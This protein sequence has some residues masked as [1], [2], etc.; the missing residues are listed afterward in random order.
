MSDS[1][2]Q[3]ER[4][5]KL[6]TPLGEEK[7]A[8]V[9]FECSEAVSE[10]FV[11]RIDA[12][13]R[14]KNLDFD[15]AIGQHCTIT[16]EMVTSEKRYFDGILTEAHSLGGDDKGNQAY[17]LVL[18]S[19][20][21]LLSHRTNCLI[22]HEKTVPDI[23][24]A[25]F[26]KHSYADFLPNLSRG[27]PTLEYCVQYRESDLD[28]V[29][30]LME[31]Y[32]ISYYFR[33]SDGAHKLVLTDEMSTFESIPGG[34][35]KFMP[36]L[37]P[38][39][40][41]EENFH[42]WMPE[43]RFTSGKIKLD[44]YDFKKPDTDLVVNEE[45]S[46][47]FDPGT[48]E[49]FD[50]PGRYVESSDGQQIAQAWRNMEGARDGHF[51]AVGDCVTCF[52]G[53]LVTLED[54]SESGFDGEYLAL[55]CVHRFG[56]QSFRSGSAG[57]RAG[58]AGQFEFIKSDKTYAPPRITKKAVVLGPQTAKVVG[59]GE[60]DVDKYGRIL[61]CFHWDQEEDQSRRCRVAQ[62]W[63]GN[64]WG[65]IYTPRVGMEVVVEFLE[66]DP[67]QPL[68]IGTVYNDKNM[69]P[70]NLDGSAVEKTIAGVKSNSTPGGDGY[71][72]FIFDDNAGK[73]L[74]RLHAQRN[75]ESVIEK[76]ESRNVKEDRTTD[77]GNNDTLDVGQVLKIHAGTKIEVICGEGPTASKITMTPEKISI[78][79]LTIDVT[80]TTTLNT[81]GLTVNHSATAVMTIKGLPVLIN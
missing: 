13:S 47:P 21:W 42:G 43:R 27:Y 51:H 74:V 10:N 46:P 63:S 44:D 60:I 3:T 26:G 58:Y 5:A 55:R 17:Q 80:A 35:R 6:N 54:K 31:E 29:C 14:E 15:S 32:G 57:G 52:P 41:D 36:R 7:L 49:L 20:F 22:F 38:H 25:I 24:Q 61:V 39:R 78:E 53:A 33:H 30:R 59:D 40:Q 1:L 81:K 69:P 73:E 18:R 70:Y 68:V 56:A 34:S 76:N 77:I 71:N 19:W 45:I 62:V 11:V 23:I 12:L 66:G 72:E 65:G 67:D 9:S 37:G 16:V 48:L 8:L 64:L 50:Y 28:F 2:G 79:A 4:I 75:L